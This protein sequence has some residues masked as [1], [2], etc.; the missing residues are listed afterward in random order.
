M[1]LASLVSLREPGVDKLLEGAQLA[2]RIARRSGMVR[3]SGLQHD[4]S[5]ERSGL[6]RRRATNDE[7]RWEVTMPYG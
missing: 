2:L 5:G 1:L 3:A 4:L 7:K 6:V